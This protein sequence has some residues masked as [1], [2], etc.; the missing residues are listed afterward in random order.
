MYKILVIA[1][2]IILISLFPVTEHT[3]VRESSDI[4]CK[5]LSSLNHVYRPWRLVVHNQCIT[6]TGVVRR[7]LK[8]PDGDYH[9]RLI[10][11]KEFR[12][13]I[14]FGNLFE[15][16]GDLVLEPVCAH[17][18]SHDFEKKACGDYK[19][20]VLIPKK[21]ERIKVTGQYVTDVMHY[22]REIHPVYSV[23]KL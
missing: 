5:D 16:H 4:T 3:R 23:S 12:N 7:V 19:S 6:V 17:S 14:N 22:W 8:E 1:A 11:D 15:L 20:N 2:G 9:I 21:G 13:T 10:V 18:S